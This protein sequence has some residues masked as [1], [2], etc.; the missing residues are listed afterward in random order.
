MNATF[1]DSSHLLVP[2]QERGNE[3][4]RGKREGVIHE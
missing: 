1:L 2:T 3:G 4:V